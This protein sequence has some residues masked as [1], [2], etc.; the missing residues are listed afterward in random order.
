VRRLAVIAGLAFFTAA[1]P[2]SSGTLATS[3]TVSTAGPKPALAKARVAKPVTWI[4][5]T[6]TRHRVVLSG[7]RFAS[8]TLSPHGRHTLHFAKAGRYP[9]MVDGSKPGV[10]VIGA[11]GATTPGGGKGKG[12]TVPKS[13]SG[14]FQSDAASNGGA[15]FQACSTSWAGALTFTVGSGGSI[16]GTGVA[17]EVPGT[18]QCALIVDPNRIVGVDYTVSGTISGAAMTLSFTLTAI[19]GGGGGDGS[20]LVTHLGFRPSFTLTYDAGGHAS[21]DFPFQYPF[22]NGGTITAHDTLTL[23]GS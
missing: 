1:A 7:G 18:A 4:N 14:L 10:V 13:W 2:A 12:S 5:A 23:S 21:E 20:G 3:I 9:Y 15:G 6:G 11:G 17:D 8:F 19:R 22:G 16:A